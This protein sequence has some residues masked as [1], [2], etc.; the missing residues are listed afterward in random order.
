MKV[1]II[2]KLENQRAVYIDDKLIDHV[3]HVEFR[4]TVGELPEVILH[5]VA[6]D[7]VEVVTDILPENLTLYVSD[8][9]EKTNWL[10]MREPKDVVENKKTDASEI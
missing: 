6:L 4:A 2:H 3:T 9:M 5:L 7:G 8:P 10:F 1:K